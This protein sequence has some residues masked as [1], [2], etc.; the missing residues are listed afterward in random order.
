MTKVIATS[1]WNGSQFAQQ[2]AA[3][4]YAPDWRLHE[5]REL[6]AELWDQLRT[7]IH[8]PL[9]TDANLMEDWQ[10]IQPRFEMLNRTFCAAQAAAAARTR[11]KNEK[12]FVDQ[13]VKKQIALEEAKKYNDLAK[14]VRT[15][16]GIGVQ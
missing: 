11:A 13:E 15:K 1:R 7:M 14:K 12:W 4:G 16:L 5:I 6:P 8:T 2:F 10:Q 9:S 3:L